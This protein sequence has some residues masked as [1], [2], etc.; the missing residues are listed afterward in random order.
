M[1]AAVAL[2]AVGGIAAALLALYEFGQLPKDQRPDR[3]RMYWLV[4]WIIGPLL[5]AII[6]GVYQYAGQ[7][8][9]PLVAFTVGSTAPMVMRSM[10]NAHQRP[11]SSERGA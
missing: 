6:S 1:L 3:D 10:A 8:L 9:K 7:E 4:V 11:I 5:G 2:G